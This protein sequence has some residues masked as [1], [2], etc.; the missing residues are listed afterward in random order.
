[1]LGASLGNFRMLATAFDFSSYNTVLDIG[2]SCGCCCVAL[3]GAH[4]H[5][6]ATTADLPAVMQMAEAYVSRHGMSD[7][8][9]VLDLDFFSPDP[10]PAADV[11]IMGMVLHDWGL[12]KK[13]MLM[14]KALAALPPGGAFIAVDNLIDD[15]RRTATIPLAMS[16]NMLLEF[17]R[18]SAF[19]YSFSEFQSWA[20][21]VGF[22]RCAVLPLQGCCAAAVAFK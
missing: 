1:M 19:D 7:R 3:C 5:L 18:E 11:V 6:H 17:G 8:V 15:Q 4:A 12:A 10:F 21:D 2:G 20:E 14:R 16:L 22:S 9:K 13:V